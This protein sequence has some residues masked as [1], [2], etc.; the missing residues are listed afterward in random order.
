[1]SVGKKV[2]AHFV[3]SHHNSYRPHILRKG[4]LLFFIAVIFVSEGMFASS[5]F[6]GQGTSPPAS[7]SVA[8]VAAAAPNSLLQN[9]GKQLARVA[10]DSKPVVPWVLGTIV[11]I[12]TIAVLFAFFMHIQIQ[13]P[14]MLFSGALVALFAL[15]LIIT[16]AQVAGMM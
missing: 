3:P 16:N 15:S 7:S 5:L 6:V 9:F 12:L 11:L 8:A 13:Q 14:E 4:W 2:H 10:Q 1:M